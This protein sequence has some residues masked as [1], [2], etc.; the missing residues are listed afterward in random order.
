MGEIIVESFGKCSIYGGQ[1]SV[2]TFYAII[3]FGVS[4]LVIQWR[5]L[6]KNG[7]IWESKAGFDRNNFGSSTW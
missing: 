5:R 7:K 4:L 6:W 3:C 2:S 1:K